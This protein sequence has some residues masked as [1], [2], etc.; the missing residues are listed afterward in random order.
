MN[1]TKIKNQKSIRPIG[2]RILIIPIEENRSGL[3]INEKPADFPIRKGVVV[4][5]GRE[6][7]QNE[8]TSF[9]QIGDTVSYLFG[10]G[11]DVEEEGVQCLVL[12][13]P[14]DVLGILTGET[15][16]E[17]VLKSEP[18]QRFVQ[19]GLFEN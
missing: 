8:E 5:I 12:R 7:L 6:V 18:Y 13:C 16:S 9:L 19:L 14:N 2:D 1:T 15:E 11:F 4:A 10:S 17:E 3:I